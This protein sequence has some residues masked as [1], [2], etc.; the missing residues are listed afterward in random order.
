MINFFI[1]LMIAKNVLLL[2]TKTATRFGIIIGYI[3][4][5]EGHRTDTSK[6]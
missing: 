1:C 2:K 6:H 5:L 3:Q 4:F